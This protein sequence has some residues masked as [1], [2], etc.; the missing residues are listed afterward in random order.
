MD[1]SNKGE[2]P[3]VVATIDVNLRWPK[4]ESRDWREEILDE[5]FHCVLCGSDLKF[6]HETDFANQAVTEEAH[7]TSCN[8]RNRRSSHRLQ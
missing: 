3:K 4:I 8:V 2:K 6:K 7:C 5:Q 1:T